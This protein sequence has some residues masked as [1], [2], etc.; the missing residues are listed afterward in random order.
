MLGRPNNRTACTPHLNLSVGICLRLGDC[1]LSHTSSSHPTLVL[2]SSGVPSLDL[3]VEREWG[4]QA[5]S[6]R[7][8][9]A[10]SLS[11]ERGPSHRYPPAPPPAALPTASD[12]RASKSHLPLPLPLPA[13]VSRSRSEASAPYCTEVAGNRHTNGEFWWRLALEKHMGRASAISQTIPWEALCRH[14]LATFFLEV[15]GDEGRDRPLLVRKQTA[16]GAASR[17]LGASVYDA[18]S[19]QAPCLSFSR[20]EGG[21]E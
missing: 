7:V 5:R 19:A 9:S 15:L 1:I 11:R 8:T 21:N 18:R 13:V 6:A 20:D 4:S 2:L 10:S 17:L 14:S 3:V 16:F 12:R